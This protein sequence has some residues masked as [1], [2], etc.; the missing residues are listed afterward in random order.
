LAR[1]RDFHATIVDY[2]GT[3]AQSGVPCPEVLAAIDEARAHGLRVVLATGRILDELTEVLPDAVEHFDVVV[4][5][6]GTML[7]RSAPAPAG[8][9]HA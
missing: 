3:I 6:D 1:E 9:A 7:Q 2:D 5:E 4:A 8:P